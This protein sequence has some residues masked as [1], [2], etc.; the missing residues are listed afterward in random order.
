M[1]PSPRQ[2]HQIA[3]D[4]KKVVEHLISEQYAKSEGD[5]DNIIVGMSEEWYNQIISE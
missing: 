5:A 3:K 2:A 1:K 4:Y